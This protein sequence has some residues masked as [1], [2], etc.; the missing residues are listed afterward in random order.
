M[1]IDSE[2]VI[3]R[4]E[5]YQTGVCVPSYKITSILS[6]LEVARRNIIAA[7]ALLDNKDR[8]LAD[9]YTST[10]Y[11][12]EP[13]NKLLKILLP[14]LKFEKMD[15]TDTDSPQCIF[16]KD[17][18]SAISHSPNQVDIDMLSRGEIGVSIPATCRASDTKKD[19]PT[20]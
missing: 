15:L 1:E 9:E 12:Y 17:I 8:S 6:R 10:S 5:R 20:I 14:Q 7:S 4:L 19:N 18:R 13:L 11:V 2:K 16:S 3:K